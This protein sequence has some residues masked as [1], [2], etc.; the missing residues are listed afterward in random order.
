MLPRSLPLLLSAVAILLLAA[1]CSLPYLSQPTPSPTLPPSA[2]PL[3]P[4][5]TPTPAPT[6]TPVPTLVPAA[7]VEAG[8]RALFLGDY[9]G[10]LTAYSAALS[11][12]SDPEIQAAGL[13][14]QGRIYLLT[15]QIS[16]ALD[17]LRAAA[18][19][20]PTTAH[21]PA[22]NYFLGRVY[23]ELDRFYE[24]AQAY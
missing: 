3:P 7:R 18:S 14:G 16:L 20:Y 13:V 12:S 21:A 19:G 5:P 15:N 11:A 17:A 8:D 10:A 1:A 24:A 9:A 4:T 6:P 2:T 23:T 22:A